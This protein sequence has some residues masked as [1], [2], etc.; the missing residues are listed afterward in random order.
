MTRAVSSVDRIL[1]GEIGRQIEG[2]DFDAAKRQMKPG[3]HL[4]VLANRL[5]FDLLWPVDDRA[6]FKVI[7]DQFGE[8]EFLTFD[9]YALNEQEHRSIR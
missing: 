7:H 2:K 6:E 1:C 4:Y 5:H 9:L 8:G 3:E